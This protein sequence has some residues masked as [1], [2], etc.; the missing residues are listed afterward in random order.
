M[1]IGRDLV[2]DSLR[3]TSSRR[4]AGHSVA[5][6]SPTSFSEHITKRLNE[7]K[8][9]EEGGAYEQL[10]EDLEKE[11]YR[12]AVELSHGNQ[13]KISKWVGVSRL[14]VREKLDK[15]ALFPKRGDGT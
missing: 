14:T 15:Y 6:S 4:A 1:G 8:Q 7:A 13:T 2:E 3:K 5:S 11:L 12:Q 9:G 10:I